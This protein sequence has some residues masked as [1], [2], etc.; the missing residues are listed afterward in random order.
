MGRS[1]VDVGDSPFVD[2]LS[3][4]SY[5]WCPFSG[6]TPKPSVN[7]WL[8]PSNEMLRSLVLDS[9]ASPYYLTLSEDNMDLE[10]NNREAE[11]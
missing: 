8:Q 5:F 3:T 6:V 9:L 7:V 1:R 2:R 10:Y 11:N 4:L